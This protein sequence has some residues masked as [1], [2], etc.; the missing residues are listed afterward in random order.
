MRLNETRHC[1]GQF[2]EMA[3]EEMVCA[4]DDDELPGLRKTGYERLELRQGAVLIEGALNEQFGLIAK[5][6]SRR[7]IFGSRKA[8]RDQGARTRIVASDSH[9]Y[10]GAEGESGEPEFRRA[11]VGLN[12]GDCGAEVVFFSAAV[13]VGALAQAHSSEVEP[14]DGESCAMKCGRDPIDD[15]VVH[16]AAEEGMGMAD[17]C[18]SADRGV[19]FFEYCFDAACRTVK[20]GVSA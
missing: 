20:E 3:F 12:E 17:Y 11:K 9:S 13:I 10:T 6:M 2:G 7:F 19:G 1:F 15:F 8:R 16:G 5:Q 18:G 14:Q 4:V